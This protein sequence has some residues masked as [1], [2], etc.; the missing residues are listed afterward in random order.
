LASP[1]AGQ[2]S[3]DG[4]EVEGLGKVANCQALFIE[5]RL[6]IGT[7]GTGLNSHGQ[8]FVINVEDPVERREIERDAT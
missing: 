8:R 2:P 7:E 1:S 3:T 5:G 4:G 6:E